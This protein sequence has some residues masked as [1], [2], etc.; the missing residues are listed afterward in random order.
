MSLSISVY[1]LALRRQWRWEK[2]FTHKK[3]RASTGLNELMLF[4]KERTIP[5]KAEFKALVKF[6][7]KELFSYTAVSQR[8][9][10]FV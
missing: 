3:S 2:N 4:E 6:Q 1:C 8:T 5:E 7:F 9:G 10:R